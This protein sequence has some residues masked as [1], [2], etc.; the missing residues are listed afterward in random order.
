[1]VLGKSPVPP[2]K[3]NWA[4]D[5]PL[6]CRRK[7]KPSSWH[8]PLQI[9]PFPPLYTFHAPAVLGL[10]W[11]LLPFPKHCIYSCHC[12]FAVSHKLFIEHLLSTTYQGTRPKQDLV[13]L[14]EPVVN[15]QVLGSLNF[16]H[17][18]NASRNVTRNKTEVG[19]ALRDPTPR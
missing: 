10:S 15:A 6:D 16:I 8:L 5:E 1:M 13:G 7:P 12:T 9:K 2:L 11:S 18:N 3:P 19:S 14:R 4:P 17:S